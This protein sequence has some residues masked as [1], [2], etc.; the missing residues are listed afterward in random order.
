MDR[1]TDGRTDRWIAPLLLGEYS[2]EG[3]PASLH[4]LTTSDPDPLTQR[5]NIVT[6]N[7]S[8]S[9]DRQTDGSTDR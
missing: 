1:Q 5:P 4:S 9:F 6:Q 8:E 2:F 7:T 3:A